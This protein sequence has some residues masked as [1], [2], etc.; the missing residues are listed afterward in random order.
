MSS[1]PSGSLDVILPPP[2]C[3]F[4]LLSLLS[5]CL[6]VLSSSPSSSSFPLGASDFAC[7]LNEVESFLS[8]LFLLRLIDARKYA[9]A[10]RIGDALVKRLLESSS[11]G[12]VLDG[13][14]DQ[15]SQ[16]FSS[17]Q[18]TASTRSTSNNKTH[19]ASD[20]HRQHTS[21]SSGGYVVRK[22]RRLDSIVA[23]CFFYWYRAREL[24]GSTLDHSVRE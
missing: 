15:T 21:S 9:E 5:L 24:G 16:R 3:F 14:G 2:S 23:K 8:L 7:C 18:Q 19:D 20:P 13:D 10:T 11:P 12:R 22:R 17:D 4:Q 6:Q 1:P